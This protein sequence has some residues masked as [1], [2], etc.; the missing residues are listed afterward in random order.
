[1]IAYLLTEQ[2]KNE[3]EGQLFAPDSYFN[4]VQDDKD[5]WVIFEEEVNGCVNPEFMWVKT[6]PTI[7]Y[8]PPTPPP[9]PTI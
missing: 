7:D 1:M 8:I 6:L 5:N 3:I 4:P 2:Q 9:I